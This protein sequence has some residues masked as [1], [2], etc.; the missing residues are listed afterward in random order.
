MQDSS[1]VARLLE[2]FKP[3]RA[4]RL[5]FSQTQN[6]DGPK[7]KVIL[8]PQPNAGTGNGLCSKMTNETLACGGMY[9]EES[10]EKA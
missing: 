10:M 5:G 8:K 3:V 9:T 6:V 4:G 7:K 2:K 1:S